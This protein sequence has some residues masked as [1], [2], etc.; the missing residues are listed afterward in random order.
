MA[1]REEIVTTP[2]GLAECCDHLAGFNVLGFDTEFVGEDAY[3]PR[4]CLVQAA[5]PGH[6]FL[7][8]PFTSGPL[9]AFWRLL[10]DPARTIVVHAGREEVRM[11]RHWS[12]QPPANLFDIQI[13]AG[14]V[15]MVYPLGHAGLV[16]Q[17]LGQRMSKGETLTEWRRR[18]LTAEQTRYAFDDVRF[19]LRMHEK[20]LAKLDKLN[21]I[22]WA[23][24]E[25]GRLESRSGGEATQEE[26]RWRK[27]R[28][29]G[30]LDRRRLGVVK[31]LFEW[32]EDRAASAN[33]PPRT[34]V[35]D[36]LLVEIAKRP[37]TKA[38]DLQVVRGLPTR[39]LEAIANVVERAWQVPLEQC[40]EPAG[41]EQDLPQMALIS[42]V[43]IAVLGDHCA[44]S[45]LAV[46][47]VAANND[48][49]AVV[50]A[51]LAGEALPEIPLTEGWRAKHVLPE[52]VSVLEGRRLVRIA[53]PKSE[54]P[55]G[56][57]DRT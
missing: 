36:D 15:G 54:S 40:P 46:G 34:V 28:G 18:P 49:R 3:H 55:L 27:L 25:F 37:P 45:K 48:V 5:V 4:L 8:D 20:L 6:I 21:R 47:L 43:L 56:Y 2:E 41:R 12:G 26:E 39:D 31:A 1:D 19:L 33:R 22:E 30:A 50:R 44:R 32:R 14:L 13:A 38:K 51:K 57:E 17:L 53:D 9:D 23:Q 52:L 16:Q 29:A 42:G 24:E 10:H 11:C 7:I 35:R